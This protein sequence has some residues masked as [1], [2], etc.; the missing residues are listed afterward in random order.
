MQ[1]TAAGGHGQA[2][3]TL[4]ATEAANPEWAPWLRLLR[5]ARAQDAAGWAIDVGLPARRAQDAPLLHDAV[6]A[7]DESRAVGWVG[8]LL[9][10]AAAE[11]D[12]AAAFGDVRG[13][14]SDALSLLESAIALD[15]ARL[16]S[17]G[18]VHGCD[19][20]RLAAV[21]Q[22]AAMPM[23]MTCRRRVAGELPRGWSLGYCALCGAWPAF[24][25]TRGLERERRARCGRC[26]FEWR[27]HVLNCPYCG[28][29]DHAKLASLIIEGDETRRIDTCRSCNGY[30]KS[31]ATLMAVPDDRVAVRD[32][33]TV[34]LDLI[35]AERGFARPADRAFPMSVAVAARSAR[36]TADDGRTWFLA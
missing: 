23:L 30:L 28:E 5:R 15:A 27:F 6:I 12:D 4:D 18:A 1:R 11:S 7:V 3:L 32:A 13:L 19:S 21:M 16:E 35:A 26:A 33:E 10:A 29:R 31:L 14:S 9:H 25:E 34:D 8:E 2:E 36:D 24:A 17:L 20:S 22:L